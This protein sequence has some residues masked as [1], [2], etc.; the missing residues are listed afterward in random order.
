MPDDAPSPQ[1]S[2]RPV[3]SA[4]L[5]VLYDIQAEPRGNAM[6]VE[7]PRTRDEFLRHWRGALGDPDVVARTIVAD[8]RV[9]GYVSRFTLDGRPAVGYRVA[10]QCWGMGIA[11][12]AL[13]LLLSEVGTRPLWARVATSNRAS[14]RVLE[15]AGFAVH[16]RVISKATPRFPACEEFVMRL[17]GGVGAGA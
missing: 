9:A 16:D 4:D 2:L 5:P 11:T 13:R 14:V 6:A 1:V 7:I 12:A 10:E 8:G 15:K 17:E 3:D